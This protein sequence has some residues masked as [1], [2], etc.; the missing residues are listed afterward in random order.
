[1]PGIPK[2]MTSEELRKLQL[3]ELDILKEVDRI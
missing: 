2:E 3:L 1:M